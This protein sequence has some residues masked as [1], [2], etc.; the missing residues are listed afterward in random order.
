MTVLTCP[1]YVYPG[2][3]KRARDGLDWRSERFS[4]CCPGMS[5][6][7]ASEKSCGGEHRGK[8]AKRLGWF[9]HFLLPFRTSVCV[10]TFFF[11]FLVVVFVTKTFQNIFKALF[12]NVCESFSDLSMSL[13]LF[14]SIFAFPWII[15]LA[16]DK[17]HLSETFK[18]CL[19]GNDP[20]V[21]AGGGG[22]WALGV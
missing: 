10:N 5:A 3:H 18:L 6:S 20:S 22:G 7:P 12:S 15:D 11:F 19:L 8:Q 9:C 1:S 4:D 16:E 17:L 21:Q 14:S 2:A 13:R